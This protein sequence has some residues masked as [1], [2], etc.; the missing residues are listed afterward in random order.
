MN[1]DVIELKTINEVGLPLDVETFSRVILDFLGR[2]ENLSYKSRDNFIISLEDVSQFDHIINSKI[3]YQK[4]IILE[5]FSINFGY[6]DGT[7]REINGREALSK[8]LETRSVDTT[9]IN[10]NWKIIVKFDHSPTIETQE[11]GLLFISSLDRRIDGDDFSYIELSINHTN[12][13]WALDILSAFKDKINEIS[14]KP[15]KVKEKYK[16]IIDSPLLVSIITM[17]FIVCGLG[18]TL[19]IVQN[20]TQKLRQDLIQYNLKQNYNDDL[21]KVIGLLNITSL[22]KSELKEL[23]KENEEINKIIVSNDRNAT[24]HLILIISLFIIP[25]VIRKYTKYCINYFDHKSFILIN[26]S[27]FKKLQN[28]KDNKSKI[29]YIGVTVIIT[30]VTFSIIASIIFKVLET[31]F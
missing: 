10:L 1:K 16:K 11:I 24:L 13:S 14:I 7:S 2:K 25:F 4:N 5:H 28:Y 9:S 18:L 6:S 31:F 21:S 17:L 30:S 12:Q 15:S 22:E 29:T 27:S 23:G 20:E 26:N 8:F 3:S 19:P